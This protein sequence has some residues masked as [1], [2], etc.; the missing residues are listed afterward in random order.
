MKKNQIKKRYLITSQKL[1]FI[2]IVALL[3]VPLFL[4]EN[5]SA[6][7]NLDWDVRLNFIETS[8]DEDYVI[9]GES[10]DAVDGSIRDDYDM[11]KPPSAPMPPYLRA[12]FDDNLSAPYDLLLADY[13]KSSDT[14]KMWNLSLLWVN[15]ENSSTT[16]TITSS[17]Q[18]ITNFYYDSLEL[19]NESEDIPVAN[20]LLDEKYS[21]NINANEIKKFN[22]ICTKEE[23]NELFNNIDV[24]TSIA[25][26]L[27]VIIIISVFVIIYFQKLRK[28][29]K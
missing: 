22:I 29:K 15:N 20:F 28:I 16:I 4:S 7:D 12:W 2:I 19:Y 5:I 13:R 3:M 8:G 26:F 17:I 6:I 27:L 10:S 21:F 1:V 11:P 18:N 25:I 9:F 24:M 14:Y 23:N